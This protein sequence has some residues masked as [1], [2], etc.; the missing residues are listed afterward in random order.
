MLVNSYSMLNSFKPSF[1]KK[2]IQ[3]KIYEKQVQNILQTFYE[4]SLEN[5]MSINPIKNMIDLISRAEKSIHSNCILLTGL[6]VIND[7]FS[8]KTFKTW[9]QLMVPHHKSQLRI[10]V[11]FD[12]LM[13]YLQEFPDGTIKHDGD[14]CA[15]PIPIQQSHF[16]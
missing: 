9:I 3:L 5:M 14:S 2:L 6:P 10:N 4:N 1:F 13:A 7:E 12:K 15:F 16:K 11:K 8:L